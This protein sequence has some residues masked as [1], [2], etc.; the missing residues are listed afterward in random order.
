MSAPFSQIVLDRLLSSGVNVAAI[1]L[2]GTRFRSLNQVQGLW[3]AHAAQGDAQAELPIVNPNIRHGAVDRVFDGYL[4]DNIASTKP[5][6]AVSPEVATSL[7]TQEQ[8]EI[9]ECG[10]VD[11]PDVIGFMDAL[12]FDIACVACWHRKIPAG[13]LGIPSFGFLNVHP[14][15]LPAY[16]GPQP[17]FWQFRAGETRTG[18]TVHWMDAGLDTGDIAAR[19]TVRFAD[20]IRMSEAE[21]KCASAGGRLLAEALEALEQGQLERR[22]QKGGSFF[23]TPSLDDFAVDADWPVR[24]AFNFVRA[25]AEYGVPFHIEVGGKRLWFGDAVAWYHT[26]ESAPE[27]DGCV[28]VHFRDGVLWARECPGPI[29]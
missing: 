14:S 17:L 21:S 24:R 11:H 10:D 2:A 12:S 13:V 4:T 7:A 1:L 3:S 23:P 27:I 9:Y 15:L 20:G 29:M 5:T 19:K 28:G 6:P 18:V 22:S 8:V 26:G 25:A 16:R